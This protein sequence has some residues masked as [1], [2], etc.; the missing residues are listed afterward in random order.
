MKRKGGKRRSILRL[1][2]MND[3]EEDEIGAKRRIAGHGG[4][5]EEEGG[6]WGGGYNPNDWSRVALAGEGNSVSL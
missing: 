5:G 4:S 3:G 6:G 1:K 2:K